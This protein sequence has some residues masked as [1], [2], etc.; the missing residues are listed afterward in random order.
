ML[1]NNTWEYLYKINNGEED[2]K[3]SITEVINNDGFIEHS[4]KLYDIRIFIWNEIDH[5]LTPL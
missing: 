1:M 4:G 3:Y 2:K 5:V